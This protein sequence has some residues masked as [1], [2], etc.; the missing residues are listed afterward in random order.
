MLSRKRSKC[1]KF[2]A[3]GSDENEPREVFKRR[4]LDLYF[5]DIFGSPTKK[6]ENVRK[7][8]EKV[9][10]EERI[11]MIGDARSDYHAAIQNNIEFAFYSPLSNVKKEMLELLKNGDF[12]CI[13]EWKEIC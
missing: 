5:E 8:L 11:V 9:K 3:S 2:V 6:V 4:G 13:N 1:K 7:I 10:E 12:V